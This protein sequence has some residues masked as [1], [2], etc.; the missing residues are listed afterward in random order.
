MQKKTSSKLLCVNTKGKI[1]NFNI[2]RRLG[3]LA[4]D[5]IYGYI[6]IETAK[7]RQNEM[8][9]L[10]SDLNNYNP[11]NKTKKK[12]EKKLLIMHFNYLLED[13]RLLMH[14]KVLF[15]NCLIFKIKN[16]QKN[17]NRL[18]KSLIK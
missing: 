18:T 12:K 2:F 1:Y 15:L 9:V 11:R 16:S 3:N 4:R 7:D 17:K 5:L 14:L 13:K 10:L 6:T 8:D